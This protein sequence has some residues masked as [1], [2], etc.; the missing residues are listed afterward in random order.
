VATLAA[1]ADPAATA[2][3]LITATPYAVILACADSR[4]VPEIV[5]DATLG[6]LFVV[7]VAGNVAGQV[8]V[9]SIEMAVERWDCPLVLVLGHTRCAAV[10]AALGIEEGERAGPAGYGTALSMNVTSL[11]STVRSNIGWS[12]GST[13]PGAWEQAV[14]A[15]AVRTRESIVKWSPALRQRIA[16]GRLHVAAAIHHLETGEVEFLTE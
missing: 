6:R 9:G 13:A 3:G 8:E 4:A 10:A 5:L 1:S 15:N 2:A 11:I 16:A 7:R 12:A 14:K